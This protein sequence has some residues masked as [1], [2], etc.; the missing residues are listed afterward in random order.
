MRII[1]PLTI[2]TSNMTSNIPEDDYPLWNSS[3]T[4]AL[5]DRILDLASHRIYQSS[6]A[7]NLNHPPPNTSYWIDA[8][9]DNRWKM[10][11]QSITSQSTRAGNITVTFT[12]NE[13]VDSV[14]GLNCDASSVNIQMVDSIDGVVYNKTL[15]LT[16]YSGI[17]DWY[18]Y[19]FEPI[20]SL[21]EFIVTDMPAGYSSATTTV[22]LTGTNASIGGLVICLSKIIGTTESG[23]KTGI[24]DYSVKTQNAFGDWVITPRSFSKKA[25]FTIKVNSSTV[26]SIQNLFASYRTVPIVYVGSDVGTE[27]QYN[28]S[29]IY[30]YYR[31]FSQ[32]ITY[33][34]L[35]T[36]SLTVE[37]LT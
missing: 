22:T 30:G 28:S 2:T 35:A 15:Q 24:V 34:P 29:I 10:F 19:F 21:P 1:R 8:G 33:P 14:V 23:V 12:P 6:V 26:D 31:D 20:E 36:C 32:I 37:G 13:R 3:T 9:Y 17:T 16:S 27:E 4:Y 25:D 18:E 5:G 7:G 11:D